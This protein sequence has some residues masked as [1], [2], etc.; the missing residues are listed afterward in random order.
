MT[1]YND[2]KLPE[3]EIREEAMSERRRTYEAP[4]V[5]TIARAEY[6]ALLGSGSPCSSNP[7]TQD[8]GPGIDGCN[9]T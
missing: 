4:V 2:D 5:E 8:Q 7:P 6:M 9:L 3:P 1:M